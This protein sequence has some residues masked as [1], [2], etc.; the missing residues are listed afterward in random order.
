MISSFFS[1]TKPINYVVLCSFLVV[2]FGFYYYYGPFFDF[3][4]QNYFFDSLALLALVLEMLIINEIVRREKV[5]DFSSFAMLFFVL[6][7]VVFPESMIDRNVVF[8]NF[9][10]LLSLWR[11]LA[12]KT[13]KNIKHKI[14]DASFCIGVA[15]LFVNWALIYLVLVFLVINLYDRGTFKN[16][17]IPFI[18]ILTLGI[19]T[20]TSF[21][22]YGGLPYLETHYQFQINFLKQDFKTFEIVKSSIYV[23]ASL[24]IMT[25]AFLKLRQKGGGKL[26]S[27]RILFFAFVLS[28]VVMSFD[29]N[30]MST[31]LLGFFPVSVFITNYLETFKQ[32]RYKEVA[33]V[34]LLFLPFFIL[35]VQLSS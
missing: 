6:L 3:L 15:S 22:L 28:V 9:F 26:L 17:F 10:L 1:K 14:F 32:N 35:G 21:Q 34:I 23:F 30:K 25:L 18:A 19:L 27:L 33:I 2:F 29:L 12:V 4:N 7:L 13:A 24:V 11:L 31:A 8:C 20:F 16:W 5:T